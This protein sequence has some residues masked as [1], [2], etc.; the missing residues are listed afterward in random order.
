MTTEK[1]NNL[2]AAVCICLAQTN[3]CICLKGEIKKKNTAKINENLQ[4][5][6]IAT[7]FTSIREHT[8]THTHR[9]H[10]EK[11]TQQINR[12]K[13]RKNNDRNKHTSKYTCVARDL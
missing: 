2:S 9:S 7:E 10:E 1:K 11:Y 3:D 5:A 4:Y 12:P 6:L 13:K 8:R